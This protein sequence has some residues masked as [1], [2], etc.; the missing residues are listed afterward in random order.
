MK[1]FTDFADMDVKIFHFKVAWYLISPYKID[2]SQYAPK[3][4]L[5][6][7]NK[8]FWLI[9]HKT[10]ANP[11]M[12]NFSSQKVQLVKLIYVALLLQIW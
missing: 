1:N 8:G 5:K 6:I 10:E 7:V 4:V 3:Q 2:K 11:N 9:A 12:F